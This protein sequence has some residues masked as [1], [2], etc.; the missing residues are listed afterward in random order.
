M[1]KHISRRDFIK[2]AGA[3]GAAGLGSMLFGCSMFSRSPA[4][5]AVPAVAAPEAF[6]IVALPDTQFY[7]SSYPETFAA[8]TQWIVDNKERLN[9]VFAAHL[10]DVST[11]AMTR[12]SGPTPGGP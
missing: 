11:P 10:G 9:I 2:V 7:S 3:V 5:T 12:P 8:Q 6:T 4:R 1:G